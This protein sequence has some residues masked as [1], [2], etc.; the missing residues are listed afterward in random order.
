MGTSGLFW[1]MAAYCVG[2]V[3]FGLLIARLKGI[4]IRK[5]GS[6]NIGATNVARVI[7][8]GYGALTLL[9]DFLKGFLPTFL[10]LVIHGNPGESAMP[11]LIGLAA[12]AG[13]CFSIFLK[14]RGGKGVATATGVI[15]AISPASFLGALI[16][17]VLGARLSGF[18][19]V[20][21]LLASFS[22][23]IFFHFFGQ[24]PFIEPFFWLITLVI[25]VQHR[26]NIKRLLSGNEIKV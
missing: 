22:A 13:H 24:D 2:A 8:K 4:D 5:E 10:Y 19:S 9:L 18:V 21:S 23:P 7:G 6:G 26:S 25:W 15:L 12:V 11:G 17:F 16:V 14:G 1:V 3:P 20:G